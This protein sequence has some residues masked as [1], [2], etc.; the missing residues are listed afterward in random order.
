MRILLL[1][2]KVK[3]YVFSICLFS[4]LIFTD[5]PEDIQLVHITIKSKKMGDLAFV[6]AFFLQARACFRSICL[7]ICQQDHTKTTRLHLTK[8]GAEVEHQEKKKAAVLL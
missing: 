3:E 1:V 4:Y 6:M 8:L 7:F 2:S 5:V